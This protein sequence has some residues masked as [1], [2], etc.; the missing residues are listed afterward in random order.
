MFI[1]KRKHLQA[2][3]DQAQRARIS[4]MQGDIWELETKIEVL[5]ERVKEL[6][7]K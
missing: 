2:L 5:E 7:K 4:E 1:S 3:A 6:E